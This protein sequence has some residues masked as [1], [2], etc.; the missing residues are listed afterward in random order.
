[1]KLIHF[2]IRVFLIMLFAVVIIGTL[3]FTVIEKLSPVDAFYFTIV[4]IATVGYGDIHPITPIGK[5]LAITLTIIGV[6]TF[7]GVIA[8]VT[9][10]MLSKREEEVRLQR[11]HIIIGV[12][13][14]EVGTKLLELFSDF[15]SNLDRMHKDVIVTQNWNE[16]DFLNAGEHLKNANYGIDIQKGKLGELRCFLLEKRNLLLDLLQNS[17]LH[18]KESFTY[19]LQAVFHLT[20]ELAYRK[21]VMQ[22]P[23]ADNAHLIGDIK[24][25]YDLLIDQWLDYMKYLKNNFPYLFSLALRTNPFDEEAS[26]IVK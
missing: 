9:E 6:G 26:P 12:F 1:M 4:T 23:D 25:V 7:L 21:D 24:R 16:K 5:F 11:L 13:F 19:L 18:E 14:S 10:L 20:E 8:N 22:L 15:T 17:T 2:R 3:G